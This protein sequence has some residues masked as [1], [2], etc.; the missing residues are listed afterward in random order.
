VNALEILRADLRHGLRLLGKS[1][2]FTAV[3]VLSLA[4]GIGAVVTVFSVANAFFLRPLPFA[5]PDR[6]VHV[7]ATDRRGGAFADSLRVSVPDFLDWREQATAF[8]DLG[9]YYYQD[10]NV[11][12]R[13]EPLRVQAG[14][15]TPNL[16]ALLGVA[17]VLGRG[18]RAEDGEPGRSRV[19][20][21]S[22]RFWQRHFDSDPGV[23]GRVLSLDG[24]PHEVVGVMPAE[25]V[26]PLKATQVWTPLVLD[27][28]SRRDS[29][30]LLVVGRLDAGQG[31]RQARAQM[32][33]IAARLRE[34]H[35]DEADRGA[36]VIPLR[37]Q[38]LFFFEE[39]R[40]LTAVLFLA[41]GF[42]LLIVCAN[43]GGLLLTRAAGRSREMAVR[44]ALGADRGRLVRQLLTETLLL[45][46]L[47]GGLG[48]I[49]ARGGTSLLGATLPEDLYRVGEVGVDGR[50]LAFAV[51]AAL[52]AAVASGLAPAREAARTSLVEALK[53]GER[54][55]G[56]GAR[57]RRLRSGLVVAEVALAT[58]LL[59]GAALMV[60][61]FLN[62]RRV[63]LGFDPRGV[64]TLELNLPRGPY[65]EAAGQNAFY[66]DVLRRTRGLPG[67][68][69]AATVYPLPLNF[70][71]MGLSFEVEGRPAA[72]G[73]KPSAGAFWIS[74]GYLRVMGIP[75]LAGSGLTERDTAE[76]PGVVLVSR[77]LADTVFPGADPIG[78]RLRLEPGT[79][80]ERAVTI[81]GVVGDS[82]QF[83]LNEDPTPLV[84]VPQLQDARRRRFLVVRSSVPPLDLVPAVREQVRA[85]DRTQ[86][87]TAVRTMDRV[88]S[89]STRLWSGPSATLGL[90]GLGALVLAAMGV[91]GVLAFSVAQRRDE[92]GLR[93]AL[94][95]EPGDVVRLVVRQGAVLAGLGIGAGLL[96]SVG[97]AR[98]LGS[99]LF[100]VTALDPVTFLGVP[101]VLAGAALLA[102]YLPARR[103][104]R[105]DPLAALRCE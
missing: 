27:P 94:G 35:P 49:L 20:L 60:R 76:A 44:L 77:H 89:E 84:Y 40:A 79:P 55:V 102:A 23:L 15:L 64:L 91:Y 41:V 62:L 19:V 34:A 26:F 18:F 31:L 1:P 80:D 22:H 69:A 78:R 83:L 67:A 54:G 33:A 68:E 17:P 16:P 28:S 92:I 75:L 25:F 86:A 103:A 46:L 63:D 39:I 21:L 88:V 74:P 43:V 50:A 98:A 42:V 4:V 70:E 58:V 97:L 85:V 95:A 5:E 47:G 38:L 2:A 11:A 36:R 37:E 6:L 52:L 57:S 96:A 99:L 105:I 71:S 12:A 3:A 59:A 30:N 32:D 53:E 61:T 48:A 29:G 104:A 51:A 13:D 45:G 14:R 100:G 73:A 10:V 56:G 65:P 24:E 7:W 101:L 81:R 9:A 8:S 90:L 93:M 82:K 87:V 66:D 72:P